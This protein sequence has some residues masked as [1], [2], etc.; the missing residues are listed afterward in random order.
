MDRAEHQSDVNSGNPHFWSS[1]DQSYPTTYDTVARPSK[2]STQNCDKLCEFYATLHI[3][4][5]LIWY[6]YTTRLCISHECCMSRAWN[7]LSV[8]PKVRRHISRHSRDVRA[9]FVCTLRVI[10]ANF[11]SCDCRATV[12]RMLRDCCKTFARRSCKRLATVAR[13]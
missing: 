6:T 4:L 9:M 13:R 7:E 5:S 11:D 2:I 12:V 8:S 1:Q 10:R 3:A